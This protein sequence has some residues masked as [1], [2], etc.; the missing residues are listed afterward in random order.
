M[1]KRS[2]LAAVVL[3]VLHAWT[4]AEAEVR[5][6]QLSHYTISSTEKGAQE[7]NMGAKHHFCSLIAVQSGGFNSTC[8]IHATD[9]GWI[10]TAYDHP[11]SYKGETQSCSAVCMYLEGV[12]P[13]VWKP[14]VTPP[15]PPPPPPPQSGPVYNNP[16]YKGYRVDR[17]WRWGV[18]CDKVAADRFCQMNKYPGA[19]EW[20]VASHRPTYVI[21]DNKVCDSGICQ[22]FTYIRCNTS[23][24]PTAANI[25]GAWK[26]SN[27]IDYIVSQ[28]GSNY[29]WTCKQDSEKGQGTISG[30][31]ISA[32]WT[33]GPRGSGSVSGRIVAD[34]TGRA[35]RIEWG[36]S[37]VWTR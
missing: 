22:G 19:A 33:G 23:T 34:A 21:Q 31:N 24:P 9:K 18:E 11:D 17:C 36:N 12:P 7:V 13:P 2:M 4:V 20:K 35:T 1:G 25:G 14:G 32:R 6:V 10:L 29:T 16:T 5:Q 8:S 27:G 30:N 15:P 3:L 28:S 26:G 37:A